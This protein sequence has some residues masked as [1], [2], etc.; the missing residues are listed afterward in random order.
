MSSKVENKYKLSFFIQ[1]KLIVGNKKYKLH[2]IFQYI[3]YISM[4]AIL[5]N[6]CFGYFKHKRKVVNL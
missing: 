1:G 5:N 4:K 3:K 6:V 2:F